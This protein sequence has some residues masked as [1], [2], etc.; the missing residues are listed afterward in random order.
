MAHPWHGAD[1]LL[2]GTDFR[3]GST[4]VR[5]PGLIWVKTT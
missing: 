2:H 5:W 3:P 4:F 1:P